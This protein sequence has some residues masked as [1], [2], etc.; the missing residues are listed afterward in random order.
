MKMAAVQLTAQGWSR[1]DVAKVL[2]CDEATVRSYVKAYRDGGIEALKCF[3]VG[4]RT[5]ELDAHGDT[6][7][8]EFDQHPP[9]NVREAQQ[10]IKTLT[11]LHRSPSQIRAFLK[12][13]GLKYQKVAPIPA[14]VDT[15]V[16]ETFVNE[17][18]DPI[19]KEAQDGK[20]HVFFVDAAHFVFAAFLGYLWC[21]LRQFLPTP[22]GRQRFNVLGA[23]HAIT[24]EVVTIT[25]T[26]SIHSGSVV[27]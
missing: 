25:N 22:S 5:S 10:R 24:H 19:L 23:L 8:K 15:T 14:K 16:Q 26:K 7:M 1:G 17:Q 20:R 4:G 6:L 21:R 27:E 11:G 3:A 12:R 13:S 9:R 18:L 2:G